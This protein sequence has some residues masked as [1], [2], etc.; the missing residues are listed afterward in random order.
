MIA[1]KIN[2][3]VSR[4]DVTREGA[5]NFKL[6]NGSASKPRENSLSVR[7]LTGGCAEVQ[8]WTATGGD[9]VLATGLRANHLPDCGHPAVQGGGGREGG[10]REVGAGDMQQ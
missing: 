6:P 3:R 10:A 2:E 8:Y 1:S 5:N 4:Q 9:Q 7:W